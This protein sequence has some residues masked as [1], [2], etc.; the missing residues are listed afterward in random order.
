MMQTCAK[1]DRGFQIHVDRPVTLQQLALLLSMTLTGFACL[2][3]EQI[4]S[5]P[6]LVAVVSAMQ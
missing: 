3:I 6:I 1:A 4:G 5:M 2:Q